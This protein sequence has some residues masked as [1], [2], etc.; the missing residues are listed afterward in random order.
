MQYH[1][2]IGAILRA[3]RVREEVK[4]QQVLKLDTES[5]Y[6]LNL[7]PTT[8]MKTITELLE[9][10]KQ[11]RRETLNLAIK[12]SGYHFG[13]S[14]S[15]TEILIALYDIVLKDEDKFI[16]SKGHA[17]WPWYVLLRERG[18]DPKIAGHPS[19]DPAN[20]VCCTTGSLGHGLPMD[21]GMAM[22][23]KLKKKDRRIY[24]LM[25]DGECQE[26][27]T[28]ES[29]LTAPHHQLDNLTAIIDCNG[30]QGSGFV[31]NILPI[32]GLEKVA[33]TLGWSVSQIDGHFIPDIVG[34]LGERV[35]GKPRMIIAH[36][37]KG[38][39]VSYMEN[40]PEW[41]SKFP[42]PEQLKQAYKELE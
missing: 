4:P 33:E 39:G 11:V 28:W 42:D 13:R 8:D 40:R 35:Q 7:K 9:R 26:G 19:I 41:H 25:G 38:R 32:R 12:N 22:A 3:G 31:E 37:I 21:I 34:A 16:L 17:C 20:G 14:F 10:S 2:R 1:Q 18:Y 29:L 27:T 36:T 5:F 15:A 30:I 24:V 23:R 6:H